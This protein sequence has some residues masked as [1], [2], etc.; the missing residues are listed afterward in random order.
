[1]K[2][3]NTNRTKLAIAGSILAGT[4]AYVG[5]VIK[6]E[7]RLDR[8]HAAHEEKMAREFQKKVAKKVAGDVGTWIAG[9]RK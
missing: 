6:R 3:Q 7:E 9:S 1:M 5:Y 4:A 8:E 2:S